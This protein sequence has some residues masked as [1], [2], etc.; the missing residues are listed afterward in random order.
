MSDELST[1]SAASPIPIANLYYMLC[2]AWD[3][4]QVRGV[5]RVRPGAR[6][7]YPELLATILLDAARAIARQ[8]WATGYVERSQTLRAPR[9]RLELAPTVGRA[10]RAS[11]QVQCAVD[12]LTVD[13]L[14]N[15]LIKAA[16]RALLRQRIPSAQLVRELELLGRQ[17]RG[18]SEVR[19]DLALFPSAAQVTSS[20]LLYRLALSACELVARGALAEPDAGGMTFGGLLRDERLMARIF[21]R[22]VRFFLASEQRRFDVKSERIRWDAHPIDD[23]SRRHL[24]TMKTDVSLRSPTHT[25][26]LDTKYY[27]EALTTHYAARRVRSEHLYQLYAYLKNLEPRGGPDRHARGVLL[28]PC[29][30]ES[31]R[32]GYE[33]PGH[34]VEIRTL[35]LAAPWPQVH[36]ALLALL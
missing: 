36:A 29:V 5:A 8:G 34:A 12:E 7:E 32:L 9:G 35:D 33:L 30:G 2:Y 20:R 6:F 22:F 14:P 28:Y 31:L 3:L 18:V 11:A 23:A 24:P 16:A 1:A 21:E 13:I 4:A 26:I 25:I 15:Q 19:L 17:L 27:A 10:L